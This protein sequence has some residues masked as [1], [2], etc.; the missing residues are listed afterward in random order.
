MKS[1]HKAASPTLLRILLHSGFWT[2]C[3][4]PNRSDRPRLRELAQSLDQ[5]KHT[6]FCRWS[7]PLHAQHD[8]RRRNVG[9][10][11]GGPEMGALVM[12]RGVGAPPQNFSSHPRS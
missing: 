9:G 1:P 12:E 10:D 2:K 7:G 5:F 8:Y 11:M 4:L 6:V 3:G